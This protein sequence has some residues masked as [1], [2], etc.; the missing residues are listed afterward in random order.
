MELNHLNELIHEEIRMYLGIFH[1]QQK[2]EN[3][4]ETIFHNSLITPQIT[5][6]LTNLFIVSL[7]DRDI[8]LSMAW[9]GGCSCVSETWSHVQDKTVLTLQL[10]SEP[11]MYPAK[12]LVFGRGFPASLDPILSGWQF[13]PLGNLLV[14]WKELPLQLS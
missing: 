11:H 14:L 7:G 4:C 6:M 12:L 10:V 3:S 9:W 5:W 8:H 1:K 13:F 2:N